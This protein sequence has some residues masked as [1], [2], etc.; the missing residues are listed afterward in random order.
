MPHSTKKLLEKEIEKQAQ[1]AKNDFIKI[2]I[3]AKK[4]TFTELS[5]DVSKI[6]DDCI[7]QFYRYET[8]SY[9]RHETGIGSG[10]G[11]NLYRAN[12]IQHI[13]NGIRDTL[14]IGWSGDDMAP[15]GSW[16]DKDGDI[17]S[18]DRDYVMDNVAK[19]IRGLED[20]YMVKGFAPYNNHWSANVHSE[21][22][23]NLKGTM[24][25]IFNT[26]AKK[27]NN[28]SGEVFTRNFMLLYD[29]KKR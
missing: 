15:Y 5:K 17:H 22:F 18:V 8:R 19:G 14:E 2:A 7:D 9:Y 24:N 29:K 16:R 4:R 6:F 26:V 11:I 25:S 12:Q 10:T 13:T 27:W 28:I 3:E 1:K 23:G 20:K 21:H